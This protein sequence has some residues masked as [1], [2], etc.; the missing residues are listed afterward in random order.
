MNYSKIIFEKNLEELEYQ[1]IE[2]FFQDEKEESN[3]LEF[4]SFSK[5]HGKFSLSL[6]GVTRSICAF[7]N[8]DGGILVFGAPEGKSVEGKKEKVFK[9]DLTPIPELMEKDRL[10][11]KISDSILPLPVGVK[12]KI[13]DKDDTYLYIFEI[14][15]SIYSPHQH[16]N[17]YHARLDGQTKPAPHYLIDALFKKISYPNLEGYINLERIS[18]DGHNYLLDISILIFN[19]SE[20]QNE[21]NI[22][23]RLTCQQGIFTDSEDRNFSDYY[24]LEGHQRVSNNGGLDV[25]HYGAPFREPEQIKI[26]ATYLK[27]NFNDKVELYL[28][29][30]GKKSPLKVSN[31]KLDLSKI[32]WGNTENPNYLF[33]EINENN[34]ISE[35]REKS[36]RSKT[37]TLK[38]LLGR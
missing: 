29:F 35:E 3:N 28:Y 30:G 14:E 12:V 22:S 37:D 4:K 13:I 1:D 5:E 7:L 20:L 18:N 36:N 32:D 27:H 23:F 31:Y 2:D 11:S 10:I 17:T 21:E 19:F 38:E 9:G 34:L 15:K 25:L 8:S 33:E 6:E 16:K 26:N 24:A